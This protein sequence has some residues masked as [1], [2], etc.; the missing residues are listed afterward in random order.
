MRILANNDLKTLS[1]RGNNAFTFDLL[2]L[3]G[4][5]LIHYAKEELRTHDNFRA[6][7][8][9]GSF[10]LQSELK[11]EEKGIL[12]FYVIHKD[13]RL[14]DWVTFIP[15]SSFFFT[16]TATQG[17]TLASLMA[18]DEELKMNLDKPVAKFKIFVDGLDKKQ[19]IEVG[20]Y[21]NS[22]CCKAREDYHCDDVE[23]HS[24]FCAEVTI[25]AF[26][27]SNWWHGTITKNA[28]TPWDLLILHLAKMK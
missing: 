20:D 22:L 8:L 4:K 26:P 14:F 13:K 3:C 12:S 24:W 25:L 17:G 19:Q 27:A 15:L 1:L 5:A 9:A 18:K 23:L 10:Y 7:D 16:R 2:G 28:E 6:V 11:D 21:M